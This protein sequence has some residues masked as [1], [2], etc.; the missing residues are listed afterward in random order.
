MYIEIMHHHRRCIANSRHCRL[1]AL[2]INSI[3]DKSACLRRSDVPSRNGNG[4]AEDLQTLDT[5][6][7]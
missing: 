3:P 2:P 5:N 7:A 6:S 1:L 4:F